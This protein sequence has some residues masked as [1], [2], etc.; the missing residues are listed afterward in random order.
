M[1]GGCR[2]HSCMITE[3][4][5]NNFQ[6]SASKRCNF[7]IVVVATCVGVSYGRSVRFHRKTGA[8]LVFT[9]RMTLQKHCRPAA[10]LL[11][12]KGRARRVIN[13]R[14]PSP[15][16][17]GNCDLH[18]L[19]W[20]PRATCFTP[21]YHGCPK[22]LTD[23][24]HLDRRLGKGRATF[25]ESD[26]RSRGYCGNTKTSTLCPRWRLTTT[27]GNPGIFFSPLG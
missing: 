16:P 26:D 19:T 5:L 9:Q 24:L 4:N 12:V 7:C 15:K 1:D 20:S 3:E 25:S 10:V 13:L 2:K 21:V 8:G 6:F 17:T 18:S 11:S 22:M 14:E 23:R 27:S